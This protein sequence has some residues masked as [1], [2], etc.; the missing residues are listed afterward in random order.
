MTDDR[1][2]LRRQEMRRD[3]VY[4]AKHGSLT[5][6]SYVLAMESIIVE[7]EKAVNVAVDDFAVRFGG[8]SGDH[9]KAWVIDQMVRAL[10]TDEAYEHLRQQVE[11]QGHDWDEG[12]AP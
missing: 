2:K 10:L 9:H 1:Q 6:P 12:I 11:E 8:I 3:A 4:E 7:Q 5:P